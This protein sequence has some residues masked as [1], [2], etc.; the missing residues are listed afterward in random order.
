MV[1]AAGKRV[2]LRRDAEDVDTR[3]DGATV[4][5]ASVPLIG[6]VPGRGRCVA[7]EGNPAAGQ[8]IDAEDERAR[9]EYFEQVE[10]NVQPV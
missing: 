4:A 3:C 9:I 7:D 6:L 2:A 10:V 1:F 5:V 8:G